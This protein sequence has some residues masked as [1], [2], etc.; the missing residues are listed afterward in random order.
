MVSSLYFHFFAC[1]DSIDI[2]DDS[3]NVKVFIFFIALAIMLLKTKA[4]KQKTNLPSVSPPIR[5]QAGR[6]KVTKLPW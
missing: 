3:A 4:Y 2:I 1:Y 5:Q 6:Q